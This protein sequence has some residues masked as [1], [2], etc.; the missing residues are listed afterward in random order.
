MAVNGAQ[1]RGKVKVTERKR[2]FQGT[3]RM[4]DCIIDEN[5]I[6]LGFKS[7]GIVIFCKACVDLGKCKKPYLG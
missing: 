3:R 1:I 6:L 4:L 5:L 7:G 2:H